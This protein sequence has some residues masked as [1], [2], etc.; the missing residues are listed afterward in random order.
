MAADSLPVWLSQVDN[1]SF[2]RAVFIKMDTIGEPVWQRSVNLPAATFHFRRIRS[3][4]HG[5]FVV[6][7]HMPA[8]SAFVLL[9]VNTEIQPLWMRRFGSTLL[10]PH[11]VAV[12]QNG[13]FLV[14]GRLGYAVRI[15]PEGN[16]IWS[17][18]YLVG[19]R[20]THYVSALERP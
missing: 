19:Q 4:A 9:R 10:E 6:A 12:L 8:L 2:R 7:A 13:D 18:R 17:N 14:I 3:T 16:V 11:D 15:S 5:G 1:S 20:T